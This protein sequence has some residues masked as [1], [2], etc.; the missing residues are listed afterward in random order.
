M[1]MACITFVYLGQLFFAAASRLY[2]LFKVILV[3]VRVGVAGRSATFILVFGLHALSSFSSLFQ[4]REH[5]LS[6]L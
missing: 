6:V 3:L 1:Y 2:K 5:D 4:W